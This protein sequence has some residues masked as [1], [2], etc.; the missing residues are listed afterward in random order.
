MFV[1]IYRKPDVAKMVGLSRMTLY[2][3]FA[4]GIRPIEVKIGP[5]GG[6]PSRMFAVNPALLSS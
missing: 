3:M 1:R 2:A 6:R 4:E 5:R